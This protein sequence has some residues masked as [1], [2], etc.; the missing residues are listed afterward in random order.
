M[1]ENVSLVPAAPSPRTLNKTAKPS[2]YSRTVAIAKAQGV[3]G[4]YVPH[5]GLDEVLRLCQAVASF[6]RPKFRERNELIIQ[7]L[8]DG[9]LRVSE[10][11]AI[12]P[13]NITQNDYGWF[14]RI[15]NEKGDR[16]ETCSIS[17]TLAA[18]LQSY[19]YRHKIAPSDKL[20]PVHRTRIFQIIDRAFETT[21]IAKPDGVG[22]VHIMRHSG[23]LE[24]LQRTGNP[25]A[26][27]EQLRHTSMRM[28][29]RYMNTLAHDE[30][31]AIQSK[32]DL[33]W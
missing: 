11:L 26:V 21:G 18:K 17:A 19:A 28:T 2:A 4:G 1:D 25:K 31:M 14:V 10:L 12:K 16:W 23:A 13:E 15:W 32:V 33:G 30:A 24:R 29:L 27:Q 22:T 9:C 20:F 6:S 5:I 3:S 8:F 7:T